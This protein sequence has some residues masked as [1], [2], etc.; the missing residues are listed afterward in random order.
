MNDAFEDADI[1]NPDEEE[2]LRLR[3]LEIG[4]ESRE[5]RASISLIRARERELRKEYMII[6]ARQTELRKER[7]RQRAERQRQL[8]AERIAKQARQ[9]KSTSPAQVGDVLMATLKKLKI[10]SCTSCENLRRRMNIWG[11]DGCEE[12]L[13]AIVEDIFPRAKEL[14]GKLHSM[15]KAPTTLIELWWKGNEG[16]LEKI[17]SGVLGVVNEDYEI[18]RQVTKHVKD[19]IDLVRATNASNTSN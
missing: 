4:R 18:R 15:P 5:M 9:I 8:K 6:T 19:A 17:K 2:Q 11:P 7:Q 16:M 14:I 1:I 12:N 3:L 10:V 13:N